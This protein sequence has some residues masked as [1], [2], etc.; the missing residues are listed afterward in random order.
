MILEWTCRIFEFVIGASR[1][2]N[3][4]N[5]PSSRILLVRAVNVL[6]DAVIVCGILLNKE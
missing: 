1:D 2:L 3:V 4:S 5:L 6:G